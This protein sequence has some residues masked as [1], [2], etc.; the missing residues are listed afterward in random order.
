ME[1]NNYWKENS[2]RIKFEIDE[3]ERIMLLYIP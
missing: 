3:L 2:F 1:Q